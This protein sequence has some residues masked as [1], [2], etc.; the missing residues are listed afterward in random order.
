MLD[1]SLM[2]RK[3]APFRPDLLVAEIADDG[4]HLA[5]REAEDGGVVNADLSELS[6]LRICQD[7]I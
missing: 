1:N 6:I 2:G 5:V 3:M 7:C 4:C